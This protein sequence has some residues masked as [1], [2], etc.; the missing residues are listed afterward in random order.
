MHAKFSRLSAIALAL[1]AGS[2]VAD[3]ARIDAKAVQAQA[4]KRARA[5]QAAD[6]WGLQNPDR[7]AKLLPPGVSLAPRAVE[8][9]WTDRFGKT[10]KV[11]ADSLLYTKAALGYAQ[12]NAQD[13]GHLGRLYRHLWT[14]LP[15]AYRGNLPA[16]EQVQNLPVPQLQQRLR[17]LGLVLTAQLNPIRRDISVTSFLPWGQLLNPI[18]LCSAEVGW[19][20][21]GIDNE[22]SA[23]CELADYA[24]LGL[25][26]NLNFAL[27]NDLTCVKDQRKRGTCS[28]HAVAANVETMIQVQGGVPTN[29]AEQE[30]YF[31]GKIF[32]DWNNR[33]SDGLVADEVY[34]AL[35][36]QNHKIQYESVWNYN[37]SPGRS[38][39]SGNTFPNS[40]DPVNYTGE[41]CTDFAFQAQEL[42]LGPLWLYTSP[43]T[44]ATGWE[45]LDWTS[46]PDY[47]ILGLPDL[48]IDIAILS[49]EAEYPVHISFN[50]AAS[51]R[52]PDANGYVQYNPA[53]P[54]PKG[55]HA[56]LA[57]GFIANADLPAGVTPDPDGRGYFIIKNSWGTRY[58]DC[59]F[60][61]LSTEF[62]RQWAFG[63]RYLEKTV[64][65]R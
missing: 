53:D 16:P 43:G 48:Q 58:G 57:V 63:F 40:C 26:R 35:D 1:L 24:S 65:F 56:I 38:P 12:L 9:T 15:A 55:S 29:L 11:M 49:V 54:A 27:K 32:T 13:P 22:N 45:V 50:T 6:Q 52:A 30:L 60:S 46:I 2:A 20:A 44:S 8:T 31:F 10:Q 61:Y 51:F 5:L 36:A 64:T 3:T 41:M 4:D 34:D 14:I 62:L 33:Y 19:E 28:V 42:N 21:G 59:G 7:F 18:G 47:T 37:Q 17:D 39:L 23:R 25:M